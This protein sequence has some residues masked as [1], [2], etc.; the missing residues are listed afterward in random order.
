MIANHSIL[1][2]LLG[3]KQN[4]APRC[5]QTRKFLVA[6]RLFMAKC[7]VHDHVFLHHLVPNPTSLLLY[8]YN[9]LVIPICTTCLSHIPVATGITG[10]LSIQGN[11]LESVMSRI[12]MRRHLS[13]HLLSYIANGIAVQAILSNQFMGL[14]ESTNIQL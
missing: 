8:S 10:N 7:A 12:S 6:Q 4:S 9:V 3:V 2:M 1:G 5:P 14:K 11:H 13:A